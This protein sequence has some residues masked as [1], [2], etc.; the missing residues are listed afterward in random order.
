MVSALLFGAAAPAV[1]Q[2]VVIR[3]IESDLASKPWVSVTASSGAA[4]ATRQPMGTLTPPGSRPRS[5]RGSGCNWT[6]AVRTTTSARSRWSSPM[7]R[8]LY[9]YVIEAS[10]D[11]HRPGSRSRRGPERS[12]SEPWSGP[13]VHPSRYGL[14]AGHDHRGVL[15]R[16]SRISEISVYNY[17]RDELILGAD[18][19]YADQNKTSN[20]LDLLRGRSGHRRRPAAR[21]PRRRDGIRAAARLQRSAR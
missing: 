7:R 14:L 17:L 11:G 10:S 5:R 19:S 9:R 21:R 16:R 1:A 2:D 18:I 8:A 12:E 20:R 6:S 4:T 15:G 13:S 3:P